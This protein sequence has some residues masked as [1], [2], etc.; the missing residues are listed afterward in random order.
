LGLLGQEQSLKRGHDEYQDDGVFECRTGLVRNAMKHAIS[1]AAAIV[2]A[3][4]V[5]YLIG[6]RE[7]GTLDI[8]HSA[9]SRT[10]RPVQSADVTYVSFTND[11]RTILFPPLEKGR[12]VIRHNEIATENPNGV[13]VV[14]NEY[15]YQST[16]SNVE[17]YIEY[18][19]QPLTLWTPIPQVLEADS[20]VDLTGVEVK[21]DRTAVMVP[22]RPGLRWVISHTAIRDDHPN[23]VYIEGNT[24]SYHEP[25]SSIELYLE[26][27]G[28]A[29]S[30]WTPVP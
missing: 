9:G 4:I 27:N 25:M 16:M 5:L 26:R 21:R 19:T 6:L 18:N 20:Y 24:Y 3:A 7:D 11:R 8:R 14:D 22:S 17:V 12:W 13:F 2:L 15:A 29:V 30:F 10:P 1:G 28:L 23:G